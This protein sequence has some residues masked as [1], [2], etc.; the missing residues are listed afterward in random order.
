VQESIGGRK[1]LERYSAKS[2]VGI[3]EKPYWK[4]NVQLS[5]LL[6]SPVL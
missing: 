1:L 4:G 6:S 5:S 2:G 3:G